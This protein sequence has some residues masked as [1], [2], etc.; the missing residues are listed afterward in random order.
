MYRRE[1]VI[2]ILQYLLFNA[3]LI[4]QVSQMFQSQGFLFQ[5]KG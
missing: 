5:V 4:M 2:I 3:H 1:A